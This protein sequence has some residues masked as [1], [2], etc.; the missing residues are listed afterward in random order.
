MQKKIYSTNFTVANK[1]FCLSFHYNGDSSYLLVNDKE[2]INFKAKDS[3]IVPYPLYLGN[4]SKDFTIPYRLESGLFGYV[5][6]F[7]VDYLAIANDRV[8]ELMKQGTSNGIKLV[9]VNVY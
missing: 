2:I 1:K 3:E 4:T 5:Y 6:D 8:L 9:N 7:S